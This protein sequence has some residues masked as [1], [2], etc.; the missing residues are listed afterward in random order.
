MEG[1]TPCKAACCNW[2]GA[3]KALY[4]YFRRR[5]W[6]II[7]L[8][9]F[10]AG[11]LALALG[12]QLYV[13]GSGRPSVYEWAIIAQVALIWVVAK[14]AFKTDLAEEYLLGFIFGLQW[15]FLTE[16]YW[17]YL[18]GKFNVMAW[19]DIPVMALT[20]WCSSLTLT[21]LLSNWLGKRLFKLA[22][23]ELLFNWKVL[24]CDAMAIQVIGVSA[25]WLWG[26]VF[27]CWEYNVDFGLGK[28]PLG[29]PWELHIG[30]W[31]VMFW[32]GTTMR[33]W[34]TKLEGKL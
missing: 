12:G 22:P 1:K 5:R 7:W 15:E 28:S 23:K 11:L 14:L 26:V 3:A 2:R 19:K 27:R 34:K 13:Q 18:P 32:Y 33:V 30:Y 9:L 29:L 8:I 24:I 17:T 16:P 21:L 25:E 4:E 20:G 10:A 6:L 31:F